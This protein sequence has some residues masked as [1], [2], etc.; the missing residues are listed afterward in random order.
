MHEVAVGG[1]Y[2]AN[3]NQALDD[4]AKIGMEFGNLVAKGQVK[5]MVEE[6]VNLEDIPDALVRLSMRHVR[7]KIVAKCHNL[8]KKPEK[9]QLVCDQK[10][11]ALVQS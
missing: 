3:D 4:L 2:A 11:S 5:P 1:A 9:T 6:V 7:G 8:K 10:F